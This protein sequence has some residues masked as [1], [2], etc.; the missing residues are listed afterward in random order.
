MA[1]SS[2]QRRDKLPLIHLFKGRK[3]LYS[4]I[5]QTGV[6]IRKKSKMTEKTFKMDTNLLLFI[7]E[8]EKAYENNMFLKPISNDNLLLKVQIRIVRIKHDKMLS[9]VFEYPAKNITKNFSIKESINRVNDL[10]K[11]TFK[12]ALLFTCNN[13]IRLSYNKKLKSTLDYSKPTCSEGISAEHNM[14]K[15]RMI[16]IDNNIYLKELGVVTQN[17]Q[18]AQ[19]MQ[20]KFRQINKYIETVDAIIKDS[21]LANKNEITIVDMGSGKGYLTFALYD[22][23]SKVLKI[24]ATVTGV[25]IRDELVT[26]CNTIAKKCGFDSLYFYKGAIKS[27]QSTKMDILIALHACDT[28]TDDAIY[29]GITSNSSIIITAPCCHKQI[30][31][32]LKVKNDLNAITKYGILEERQAEIVT[33]TLRGLVLEAHGYKTQIFEFIADAH[34]HKNVMI[35]GVKNSKQVEKDTIIERISNLKKMFGINDF[36]LENILKNEIHP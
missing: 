19:S 9:F 26:L 23:L 4:W 15:Y 11:F 10:L 17:N 8:F 6:F 18:I 27:Y 22:F 35:V 16:T 1:V 7:E 12:N 32:E 33:D 25:E 36:Y 20:S 2:V 29:Q 28:A 14:N 21:N 13:D 30:R 5:K 24:K 3:R 31:K 34:T